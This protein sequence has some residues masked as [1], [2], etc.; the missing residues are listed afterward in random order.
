MRNI[1]A[2]PFLCLKKFGPAAGR[3]LVVAL[4]ALA[5][6]GKAVA[7]ISITTQPQTYSQDFNN[8]VGSA[9]TI[10]AGWTSTSTVWVGQNNGSSNTGGN[11]GH[12]VVGSNEYALGA[13]RS[14]GTGN[15]TLTVTF[16]NNT[17]SPITSLTFAW[18]YEQWR[19]ANAS[20]FECSA[21]GA[22][23]G[24]VTI[25]SKDFTGTASGTNGTVAITPVTSFTITGLS[26]ANGATFGISFLTTDDTNADNGIAIDDF[27]MTVNLPCTNPAI[28]NITPATQ[29]VCLNGTPTNLQVTA[30]GTSPTYQW[31]SNTVNSNSGGTEI[32]GAILSA[33]TPPVATAGTVYYYAVV[34]GCSQNISSAAVAVTVTTPPSATI[35]YPGTPFCSNSGVHSVTRTGSPGG[36]YSAPAG[37]SLNTAT[38]EIDAGLSTA[39]TYTVTYTMAAA[40]GCAAQTATSSVTITANPAATISYSAASYCTTAGVQAVTRTGTAGGTYTATPA[41]LTINAGTGQITPATSATGDYT[42]TYTMTAPGNGCT[43]DQT[44]TTTVSIASIATSISPAAVQYIAAENDGTTLTVSEGQTP[45]SRQWKYGTTPGGPYP[46]NLGTDITTT[47]NFENVGTYYIVCETTYPA[48][49]CGGITVTSNEVEVN[50]SNNTITTDIQSFGPFCNNTANPVSVSFSY[51]P[52]GNFTAGVAVFTAE[53]SDGNGSF[54]TPVDIGTVISDASGS[55]VISATIPAAVTGGYAFKIRVR[56][57][58]PNTTGSDNDASFAIGNFPAASINYPGSPYC[59]TA[60]TQSVNVTGTGG[61]SFSALP[62]GL[63]LNPATGEIEPGTSAPGTYTVTYTIPVMGS[64]PSFTTTTS[65]TITGAPAANIIYNG[66][67]MCSNGAVELVT[68]T[69]T[70]GGTFASTAG[71]SINAATGDITPTTSTAGTYVVNYTIAAAGGCAAFTASTAVTITLAP[72]AT[73]NY[74]GTPFCDNDFT[75]K[76]VTRTGTTG[77][78]YTASPAGLSI[79]ASTGTLAIYASTA[80][81]YTVTYSMN[82]VGGCPVQTATTTVTINPSPVVAAVVPAASSITAPTTTT[83][84]NATPGGTWSSGNASIATVNGAGLVTPHPSNTGAVLIN[85]TVNSGGCT[86]VSSAAINVLSASGVPIWENLINGTNPSQA[87]NPFTSGDVVNSNVTVSGISYNGVTANAANDRFNASNW[88]TAA[89]VD[90][91]KY[92]SF[93]MTSNAGYAIDFINFSYTMQRSATGPQT[94]AV[95][96]SVDGFATN[97]ATIT[98]TGTTEVLKNVSLTAAAYQNISSPITYRIYGYSASGGGGTF[99]I[100]SFIFTGNLRVLCPTPVA[101]EF[102]AQPVTTGQDDIMS[103]VLVRARCADGITAAAYTGPVVLSVHTGCGY[104]TQTVNAVNGIAVFSNI[105]FRRSAQTNVRLQAFSPGLGTA[106]SDPFDITAPVGV[107]PT[108]VIASENFEAASTWA[109]TA[110]TPVVTGSGGTAGTDVVAIKTFAGNN[111]LA[112]SYSVDNVS[113]ERGTQNTITFANQA[114]SPAYSHATFNIQVGS[115][116]PG[117]TGSGTGHDNGEQM[118]IEISLDGGT[119]W[120]TMVTFNGNA[121]YVFPVASAP[122]VALAYN[123][124]AVYNKPSSQSAFSVQLPNGTTQFRFRMVG[125]NNR[126]T[127]NWVL[128]NISLVGTSTPTAGVINPMPTVISSTLTSC[129]STNTTATVAVT[130]TVGVVSYVWTPATFISN[131]TVSNPVVNPPANATYTATI[132]DGDGCTATGTFAITMP[133]GSAGTWTGASNTDWFQCVNWGAGIVP[134]GSTD[135][136]IPAA[137]TNAADIDPLSTFSAPYGGI[138]NVRDITIDGKALTTQLNAVVNV[139]GNLSLQNT[140]G[141]LNMTGGGTINLTGSWTKTGGATFTSGTGTINYNSSAAQ[142]IAAENYYNLTS[143]SAGARTLAGAGTIGVSNIFTPGSNS[144]TITGST[145][146]FNKLGL[147]QTIPAFTFYNVGFKNG[148]TKTLDGAITVFKTLTVGGSTA[149]V[150]VSHDVTLKSNATA[151]ANVATIPAGASINQAGTGRFIL[152]RYFDALRSWRLVTVPLFTLQTV[153]EAW[154]EGASPAV[155]PATNPNP[156]PGYGIHVSGPSPATNGFDQ[157]ILNNYSIM[158][159]NSGAWSGTGVNTSTTITSRPGWMLFVRGDRSFP[160]LTSTQYTAPQPATIRHK[161]TINVGNRPT[162]FLATGMNLIGNPYPSAINFNSVTKSPA[163]PENDI[164]HVWDPRLGNQGQWITLTRS[165]SGYIASVPPASP[166]DLTTGRIESGQAFMVDRANISSIAIRETDKSNESSLLFRPQPVKTGNLLQASMLIKNDD[167]SLHPYD[168]V[169]QFF[170]KNYTNE[171]EG[172]DAQKPVT[173]GEGFGIKTQ[174]KILSVERRNLPVAGDTIFYNIAK[175]RARNYVLQ[176]DA[177]NL[178]FS[179]LLPYLEDTYTNTVMPVQLHGKT[180]YE[181][182]VVNI[183][184]AYAP[185]RF[186]IVFRKQAEFVLVKANALN[187]AVAVQWKLA[188]ENNIATYTIER[189]TTGDGAFSSV[190]TVKA[191]NTYGADY[192]FMDSEVQPGVYYYRIKATTDNGKVIYSDAVKAGLAKTTMPMLVTPNP[193]KGGTIRVLLQQSAAGNYTVK[194]YNNSGQPLYSGI[195]RHAGGTALQG[196]TP[197]VQLIPGLYKLEVTAPDKTVNTLQVMIS[198][199]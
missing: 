54:A 133:S 75:N 113:G 67:P 33:Y 176:F 94:F 116:G 165:G 134:N 150:L 192:S 174:D 115:M 25:N 72:A 132:T 143:S 77:G 65:V 181:F 4:L 156:V 11:H 163:A 9:A 199:N 153:N 90:L 194:L 76:T 68:R 95:R 61:G 97:I 120:S 101:I 87:A 62:A 107:A 1:Y 56:S 104:T 167:G 129:P 114:I 82:A 102:I 184:G 47:P 149:F 105:A 172:T 155:A 173:V 53:L 78:T 169:L 52:A 198:G 138:V 12:G 43:V 154:M 158:R 130:N 8:Y 10:P 99:S 117:G 180:T 93:T 147:T 34:S 148:G 17:G 63:A 22:L 151:T 124:N 141:T 164:F 73:I 168:G 85:Y 64:C 161:G 179:N 45:V 195:I 122:V 191:L 91:N 136:T 108:T 187:N 166:I 175:M 48:V 13:L 16:Q 71:L 119:Q 27:S 110:G 131:T 152:E 140:G 6:T 88:P 57:N 196:I 69:G 100:N 80:G 186:R 79:D 23:A 125:N 98:E 171:V 92:F 127:E 32:T 144:Y 18:N 121:D 197:G 139:G 185:G 137:A 39:G 89:S 46:N 29:S 170:G 193:V 2:N 7:Q 42:I 178:N 58:N 31:Y 3:F 15:I 20:G 50:V 51:S 86:T 177:D 49:P 189:A 60:G 162:F 81:T 182:S 96:S 159:Y 146:D 66:S 74:A 21:T 135:V 55:Q 123:A 26:I 36:T 83:V 142:T 41:G 188:D 112:K 103:P 28:T 126:S 35:S 109:Y 183:P 70:A 37:L 106:L 30:T 190:G 24:N 84:S 5:F 128:D 40:G 160:I 111:V 14:G 19:F 118:S 145:I 38:G 157:T 44:T 59:T